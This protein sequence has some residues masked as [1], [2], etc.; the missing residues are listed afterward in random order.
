MFVATLRSWKE[1]LKQNKLQ[2]VYLVDKLR[3]DMSVKQLNIKPSF[4]T[5]RPEPKLV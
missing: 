4:P 3:G 5:E 2:F 1:K